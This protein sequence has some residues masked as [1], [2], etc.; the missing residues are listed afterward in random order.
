MT[1]QSLN[2]VGSTPP[3]SRSR[4]RLRSCSNYAEREFSLAMRHSPRPRPSS[5]CNFEKP[6]ANACA[7]VPRASG[8]GR[9]SGRARR[10][11]IRLLEFSAEGRKKKE[12]INQMIHA[13]SPSARLAFSQRGR[14]DARDAAVRSEWTRAAGRFFFFFL[15][16]V[17]SLKRMSECGDAR[18]A[19][20]HTHT[21]TS[22]PPSLHF[23]QPCVLGHVA[24]SLWQSL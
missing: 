24:S 23:M 17:A 13:E 22:R 8:G 2:H 16:W 6:G 1:N 9:S 15:W 3:R 7:K 19:C 11:S 18:Q 10:E 14:A 12:L 4:S 5:V 21:H 20:T